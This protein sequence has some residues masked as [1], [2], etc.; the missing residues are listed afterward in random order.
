MKAAVVEAWGQAPVYTD[1]PEPAA[2]DG[3][4]V[5]TVEASALTNLTRGLVSGKHYASKEFNSRPSP[6]STGSPG[7]T[8]A[9]GSTPARW[10][11]TA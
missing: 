7:S 11:P 1:Y 6:A 3:A 10:R 8:T 9:A 2:R 5:A 4:V